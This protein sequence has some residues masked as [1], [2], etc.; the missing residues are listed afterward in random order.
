M[1]GFRGLRR[2]EI[3]KVTCD[4]YISSNRTMVGGRRG[5]QLGW[6]YHC[7]LLPMHVELSAHPLCLQ[8][9]QAKFLSSVDNELEELAVTIAQTRKMVELIK[10]PGMALLR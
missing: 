9:Q 2:E 7:A 4:S 5:L 8:A 6:V 1:C 3:G 10:V